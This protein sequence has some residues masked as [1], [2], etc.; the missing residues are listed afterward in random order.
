MS[1]VKFTLVADFPKCVKRF[2]ETSQEHLS[3]YRNPTQSTKYNT[4]TQREKGICSYI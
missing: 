4:N 1:P 3:P 2:L